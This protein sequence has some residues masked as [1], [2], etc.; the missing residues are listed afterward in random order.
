MWME[1]RMRGRS[2]DPNKLSPCALPGWILL[3]L[4]GV[5]GTEVIGGSFRG[6]GEGL[7]YP[8]GEGAKRVVRVGSGREGDRATG[9][10]ENARGL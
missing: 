6:A 4:A 7:E 5:K 10:E 2:H 1:G 9:E 3:W 8:A